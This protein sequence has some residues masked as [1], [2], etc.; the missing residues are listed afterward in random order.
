MSEFGRELD[1]KIVP[2]NLIVDATS[3][4]A[5]KAEISGVCYDNA[6][7]IQIIGLILLSLSLAQLFF[8]FEVQGSSEVTFVASIL[9]IFGGGVLGA[10]RSFVW[11]QE[12]R[13]R[14]FWKARGY[15][16]LIYGEK[17][18]YFEAKSIE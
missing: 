3:L 9:A 11:A 17:I 18:K 8:G 5:K 2:T 15:T 7:E 14:S 4:M 10:K 6:K 1:I 13:T 16:F 12:E